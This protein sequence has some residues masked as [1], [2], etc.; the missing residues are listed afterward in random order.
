MFLVM[1]KNINNP[2]YVTECSLNILNNGYHA[3]NDDLKRGW[4]ETEMAYL[5]SLLNTSI[6]SLAI[7]NDNNQLLKEYDNI[8]GKLVSVYEHIRENNVSL[9]LDIE[10]VGGEQ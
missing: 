5:S 7:Y 1:N 3:R 2:I 9:S 10:T 6:T 8:N 4:T